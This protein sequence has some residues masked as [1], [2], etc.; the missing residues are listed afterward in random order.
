MSIADA[1]RQLAAKLEKLIF[2]HLLYYNY[3]DLADVLLAHGAPVD[4]RMDNGATPLFIACEKGH[5]EIVQKLLDAG[6]DPHLA[7]DDGVTVFTMT[8]ERRCDINAL[9]NNAS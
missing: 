9:L 6:A 3:A 1:H 8:F 5:T 2:R 4:E 7:R